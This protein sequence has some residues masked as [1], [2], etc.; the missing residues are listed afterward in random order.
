MVGGVSTQLHTISS[1]SKHLFQRAI[2]MSGTALSPHLPVGDHSSILHDLGNDFFILLYNIDL[3]Y[4]NLVSNFVIVMF[5]RNKIQFFYIIY[6]SIAEHLKYRVT[7]KNELVNFLKQIDINL[8][9]QNIF[10]WLITPKNGH[11]AYRPWMPC[12]EGATF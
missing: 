5:D 4:Y 8:L 6:L 10:K 9:H 7:N 2:M 1:Q 11:K 12:V 3:I